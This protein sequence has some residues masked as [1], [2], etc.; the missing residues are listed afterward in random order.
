MEI[1][2]GDE[3]E[4]TIER[5]SGEGKTVARK[6]GMVFFVEDAVPGD[7]VRARVW[8]LQKKFAEAR[9]VEILT[10]SSLRTIPQCKH[11]GVCG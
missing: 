10:S 3:I 8:K 5:L 4:L 6:D 7:V 11:F 2:K 1:N 9:T